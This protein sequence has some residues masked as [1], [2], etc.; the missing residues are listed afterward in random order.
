[1]DDQH[2]S[3]RERKRHKRRYG[4]RITNP[5]MRIVMR[6]LARKAHENEDEAGTGHGHERDHADDQR[7]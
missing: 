7:R 6:D 1:M 4:P 5:G 3:D 2:A